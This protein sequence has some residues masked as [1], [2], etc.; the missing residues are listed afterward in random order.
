MRRLAR[1]AGLVL[2]VF[3]I[4]PQATASGVEPE[5][6][7]G[8]VRAH[9]PSS[10]IQSGGRYYLF[11]TGWGLRTKS[12]DDLIHWSEGP[13]VFR[14]GVS[15]AWP[16]QVAPGFQ[17]HFWAPDLVRCGN[18]YRL[19]YSVS[20]FGKQTSAIGLA[21][22]GAFTA[23]DSVLDWKDQGVVIQSRAGDPYNAIDPSVLVA[24][25]GRHWLAFGSFW[26]GIYLTELNPETGLLLNPTTKPTR[27]AS[28]NE[29]EAATLL[30]H[31]GWCY[32]F[33]N[34]G[35]CCRGVDST[36]RVLVG[37]SK[38]VEGPYLDKEGRDL[39]DGGGTLFLQSQGA[40]IGPGHIALLA[41]SPANR[42]AFHY[43]DGDDRGKS[44][45]A[46][47]NMHWSNEGWP[48][49]ADIHLASPDAGGSTRP[50]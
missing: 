50:D 9:D 24:K 21:T 46:M 31:E 20:R 5:L 19:Y 38:R 10:I 22:S 30:Q 48:E 14:R 37:R 15:P 8:D 44:K 13:P 27:I 41:D 18:V 33:V 7:Q 32:L 40:Q 42:F 16:Q 29:I 11:S 4:A 47:A 3:A 25:D 6:L 39:I 26:D 1:A 49:A 35:L 17:G 34:H 12:S 2:S 28:A 36:Y 43:Y 45:L 23:N